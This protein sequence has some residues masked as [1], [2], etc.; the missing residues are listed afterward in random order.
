MKPLMIFKTYAWIIATLRDL[1]PI[2]L[3]D[4]N[5]L[6]KKNKLS[7]NNGMA[8]QTFMRYRKDIEEFFDISIPCDNLNRY[9]IDKGDALHEDSVRNWMMA[10]MKVNS[11]FAENKDIYD[12]I[13]M[14]DIPSSGMF[15][16]DIVEAMNDN[17]KV[18]LIY[19]RYDTSKNR[20][21]TLAPYYLKIYNRRWY[22]LGKKNDGAII[23]FALDRIKALVKT[24][25]S[26]KME[27]HENAMEYFKDCYGVM[28]D[29]TKPAERIV[30]RAF[31]YEANYMR[32]L[33]LHPSQKEIAAGDDYSDFEL[34]VRP[35]L[36][37]R[38]KIQ[39]R[40][41]RLKVLEPQHLADEILQICLETVNLYK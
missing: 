34:Y 9:F 31:G 41:S 21:H 6:W 27:K 23:T 3:K 24:D 32:D 13:V 5:E 40:G 37:L 18:D 28:K 10:S 35:S 29:E 12:R 19:Q 39:E 14:E 30:L 1:G 4:I 16:N 2:T 17:K 25:E 20:N 11:T 15:L 38:G 33:K 26:F 36:D 8:R 7:E 22:M